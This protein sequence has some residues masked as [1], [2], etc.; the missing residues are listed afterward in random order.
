MEFNKGR[1]DGKRNFIFLSLIILIKD[2]LKG[3][4]L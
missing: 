1:Y 2:N 3:G 4:E